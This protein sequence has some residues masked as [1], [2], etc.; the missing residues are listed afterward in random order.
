MHEDN[1][2]DQQQNIASSTKE[3]APNPPA[4]NGPTKQDGFNDGWFFYQL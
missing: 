3:N 1:H 4:T 2:I